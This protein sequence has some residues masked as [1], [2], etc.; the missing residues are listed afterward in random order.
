MAD[1]DYE[2]LLSEG[3]DPEDDG[4]TPGPAPA[5]CEFAPGERDGA[6]HE[7][8]VRFADE[9][10]DAYAPQDEVWATQADGLPGPVDDH[11]MSDAFAPPLQR[12]TVVCTEDATT[13]VEVFQEELSFIDSYRQ[14]IG[15]KVKEIMDAGQGPSVGHPVEIPAIKFISNKTTYNDDGE[16]NERRQFKPEQVESYFGMKIARLVGDTFLVLR[17][18]RPQCVNY[19]RQVFNNE[20]QN[21]PKKKDHYLMF[22]N[23]AAR[24]AVGGAMMSLRD[25]AIYACSLREPFDRTSFDKYIEKPDQ[26]RLDGK[27]H[28][29]LIPIFS[30]PGSEPTEG[31]GS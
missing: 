7:S 15:I 12:E 25:E 26:E 30:N 23:C 11:D 3:N 28:L 22:R 2:K 6:P 24:R 29:Q 1:K 18:I 19:I 14:F 27:R 16:P 13:F 21:D 8:Q 10:D 31:T 4:P 9:I 5:E 17:P 20:S